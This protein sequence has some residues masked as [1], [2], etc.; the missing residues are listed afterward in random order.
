M[1][2]HLSV[3]TSSHVLNLFLNEDESEHVIHVTIHIMMLKAIIS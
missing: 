3:T 1:H 2:V